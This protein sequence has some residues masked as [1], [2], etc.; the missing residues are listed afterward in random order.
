MS[1]LAHLASRPS[2]P[3]LAALEELA[4]KLEDDFEPG[5]IIADRYRVLGVIGKGGMG[6]VY[7]AE[8]LEVGRK[9]A[10]KVLL[11]EW[12]AHQSIARRFRVEA[13]TAGSLGHPNIV[14]VFDAG[15]LPDGRLFLAMENLEGRDLARELDSVRTLEARRACV[16]MRQVAMALGAG[17]RA[18]IV[19][20]D[21]KPSNVMLVPQPDGEVAKVLDFGIAANAA[22]NAASTDR[23]TDP[24]SLMGTPEYMAPEQATNTPPTPAFD[25]YAVGVMLYELLTGALPFTAMH[26]FELLT[27]KLNRA[28]PSIDKKRPELPPLLVDL[29]ADCLAI[30]P[31]KRPADGDALVVRFDEVLADMRRSSSQLG[32]AIVATRPIKT[33]I[34]VPRPRQSLARRW[35]IPAVAGLAAAAGAVLAISLREPPLE[36][37]PAEVVPEVEPPA[38]TPKPEPLPVVEPAPPP[39]EPQKIE[40]TEPLPAVIPPDPAPTGKTPKTT[41]KSVKTG[42]EYLTP[43]CQRVRQTAE[44]ARRT[45]RWSVLRDNS[46]QRECWASEI[47]ARRLLTKAAMELGDFSACISA[48]KGLKDPEVQGWLKVCQKRAG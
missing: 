22:L 31:A 32:H 47:E 36:A 9:V 12:S 8:H 15:A 34:S 44:E 29:V 13:R 2:G 37:E 16:L 11:A 20:R 24:G 42:D 46:K 48:G 25:V 1:Q 19:H 23:L 28:A 10:I 6:T 45:Q 35:L 5:T 21:V 43:R 3:E 38:E 40:P 41:H 33:M 17:H 14:Q 4:I 30:D 26:T 7:L 18:G 27:L 39:I